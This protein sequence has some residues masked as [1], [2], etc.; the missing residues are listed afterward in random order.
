[1]A[2]LSDEELLTY[3]PLAM[4]LAWKLFK[5]IPSQSGVEYEELMSNAF[6]GLVK[7]NNGFTEI[8]CQKFSA[9]AYQRITGEM[10]DYLRALDMRTRH[11][12]ETQIF[13]D[14]LD[15]PLVR[16]KSGREDKET[17]GL[18][19]LESHYL[20]AL[21]E[22]LIKEN[23]KRIISAIDKLDPRTGLIIEM[24][25]FQDMMMKEISLEIGVNASRISQI[26]TEAKIKL[27]ELLTAN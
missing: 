23:S 8:H 27:R 17:T 13:F 6:I 22:L 11:D 2:Y 5:R 19:L 24:Y 16:N 18:D 20:N 14:H 25:F 7:A 4:S 3:K 15:A 10:L 1:M 21:D 9:Y 26:I 12:K